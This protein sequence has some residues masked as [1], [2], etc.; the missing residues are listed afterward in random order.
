M[1]NAVGSVE[2]ATYGD[3]VTYTCNSGYQVADNLVEFNA[4]CSETGA[5]TTPSNCTSKG[6][7]YCLLIE[8]PAKKKI[9]N[10]KFGTISGVACTLVDLT[11]NPYI[12]ASAGDIKY[13]EDCV[14]VTCLTGYE[15]TGGATTTSIK[16]MADGTMETP[17]TCKS[18][19]KSLEG[20][21]S[22]V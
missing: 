7:T 22:V 15:Y 14:Y 10:F 13:Y 2:S 1:A 4:T 19:Q 5:L 20:F 3:I 18:M 21:R 12:G 9:N 11:S 16:C 17:P 6:D 8:L